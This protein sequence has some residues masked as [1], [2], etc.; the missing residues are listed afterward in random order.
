MRSFRFTIAIP[1]FFGFQIFCKY[2]TNSLIIKILSEKSTTALS[3]L[4]CCFS[5]AMP[6]TWYLSSL[7]A[8]I[9]AQKSQKRRQIAAEKMPKCNAVV[10]LCS[11][12][13]G[14]WF[15]FQI[16]AKKKLLH[17]KFSVVQQRVKLCSCAAV[18]SSCAVTC[19]FNA[20][21]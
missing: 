19:H 18:L 4:F 14:Q 6:P 7:R 3:L 16:V 12:S 20:V 8:L 13:N 9:G 10:Q 21:K 17:N 11:A 15:D 5:G 1:P 2:T